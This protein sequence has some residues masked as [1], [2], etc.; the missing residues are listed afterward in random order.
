MQIIFPKRIML[1]KKPVPEIIPL[2]STQLLETYS[3]T[4]DTRFFE[5]H[6]ISWNTNTERFTM[7]RATS[8]KLYWFNIF[9]VLIILNGGFTIVIL[10]REVT[11]G[12]NSAWIRISSIAWLRD[13]CVD[14][15]R[16]EH[17]PQRVT[18]SKFDRELGNIGTSS[19]SR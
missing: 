8:C 1:K 17:S 5:Q 4:F 15:L 6:P 11:S 2:L 19:S 7:Y 12:Q 18:S 13:G 16:A 14:W 10:A 9:F 3:A